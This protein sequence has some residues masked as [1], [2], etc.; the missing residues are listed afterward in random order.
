M[1]IILFVILLFPF[2]LVAQ[3]EKPIKPR[4]ESYITMDLL[5]TYY[6][7]FDGKFFTPRRRF[8]FI[9]NINENSKVGLSLGFGNR[10]TSFYNTGSKYLLW[11]IR[12][13]Y[14]HII[15]SKE[16]AIFYYS[17]ELLYINH[18]EEFKSQTFRSQQNNYFSFEEADYNRQKL[19]VIPKLGVFLNISKRIGINIYSGVGLKYRINSY[20]NITNLLLNENFE[21]ESSP[22]YRNEGNQ[23]GIEF[24]LGLKLY[25][26]LKK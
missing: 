18:N 1:K 4:N 9:K 17:I 26:R 14:Y 6:A 21:E 3:E 10:A 13:E 23:L 16:K 24:S 22:Y 7:N 8:G 20:S 25:Y 5:S 2:A 11:E 15:K 12:P 19:G